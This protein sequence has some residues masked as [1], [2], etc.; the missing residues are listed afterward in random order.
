V[1]NG[2]KNLLIH[3]M[4]P[5]RRKVLKVSESARHLSNLVSNDSTAASNRI[6]DQAATDFFSRT[7]RRTGAS[8]WFGTFG[9]L[10]KTNNGYPEIK[11]QTP[12]RCL[13]RNME[14]LQL[15]VNRL[16][17]SLSLLCSPLGQ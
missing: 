12:K 13:H 6:F 15:C 16:S 2:E 17:S 1:V 11:S 9:A 10:H 5:T 14:E 7:S 3:L 8:A 4:S